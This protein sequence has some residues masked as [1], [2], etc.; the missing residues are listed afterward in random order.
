MDEKEFDLLACPLEK[1]NLIEAGAGTGKTYAI[2]GL[3]LRLLLEKRLSI[4]EILVVTYTVAATE[5]LRDRIRKSIRAAYNA[6]A[7]G[8]SGDDFIHRLVMNHPGRERAMAILKT[9]LAHFDEAPILTI[10]GFC[11]RVLQENAFESLAPFDTVLVP[12]ERILK[13]EIVE[14]FWRINFYDAPP[15]FMAYAMY[16]RSSIGSFLKLTAAAFAGRDLKIDSG[17]AFA[18]GDAEIALHDFRAA[19][20]RLR[21]VWQSCRPEVTN[22]LNSSSLSKVRYRN[23]ESMIAQMD[24]YLESGSPF[25]VFS[26]FEK[27][28]P[29]ALRAA[30][31]KNGKTPEHEFFNRCGEFSDKYDALTRHFEA[32][33]MTLKRGIFSYLR[34][35]L[36]A[37]KEELN[38]QFYDDLLIR[39]RE[40]L[41]QDAS[42]ELVHRLRATYRAALVDEFQDTDPVQFAIFQSVFD[43]GK[44]PLFLIGDPKQSIYSFRG[45]DLFAYMRAAKQ[46]SC[47]YHMKQ[48]F[49]SEPKLVQAVNV[50][51]QNAGKAPF[52][53]DE[54][55]FRPATAA[56]IGDRPCLTID[57]SAEAP[58]NLWYVDAARLEAAGAKSNRQRTAEIIVQAVAM[59]IARLLALGAQGRALI[60]SSPLKEKDMAVLVRT[61]DQARLLHD[62]IAG[63]GIP[64]VLHSL[65]N[66]FDTH[67]AA[68]MRRLLAG[69]W[70]CRSSEA[71]RAAVATDMLGLKGE[72]MEAM[73]GREDGWEYWMQRF[74]LYNERWEKYGFVAMFRSLLGEEKVRQR[75]LKFP[76]G[77]RRVTNVLQLAEVLQGQAVEKRLAMTGLIKW[78]DRQLDPATLRLEE[79][80]LRLESDADAVK[81]VT[82][83]K[84]KGL[85]YPVVFCP[86]NWSASDI[87]DDFFTFHDPEADWQLNMCLGDGGAPQ[88]RWARKELLAENIRLLY[89]SVTRARNRCYLVWGPFK[90]ADSSAPAYIL[91]P[92]QSMEPSGDAVEGTETNFA[93]LSGEDIRSQLQVIAARSEGAISIHDGPPQDAPSLY[94]PRAAG[95]AR[96]SCR[97]AGGLQNADRRV[98]SFSYIVRDRSAATSLA[99][100]E[101][102]ELSESPDRDAGAVTELP[103]PRKP[104]GFFAFPGGARAGS[105]LHDILEQVDFRN[106]DN[107]NLVADKLAVYGFDE[108]WTDEISGMIECLR[109]VELHSAIQGLKLSAVAKEERVSELQF[110]FPLKRLTGDRLKSIFEASGLSQ[111]EAFP[112]WSDRLS[113][114][115]VS[116]CMKGFLDLVFRYGGRYY[117]VDWKSNDLGPAASDY[118]GDNLRSAMAQGFYVLQ[119]HL[120]LVALNEYLRM[121]DASYDYEKD[122]GGVFYIFLRGVDPACGQSGIYYDR[123]QIDTIG[124]LAEHLLD[125]DYVGREP[126]LVEG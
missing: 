109:E 12:D 14:D 29:G 77:E 44:T 65:G 19:F 124:Y 84:S 41:D 126:A 60:G 10:H 66:L 21:L 86:F 22:E 116:G 43:G 6:F 103:P 102:A 36:A 108:A 104:E 11:L 48:N 20:D 8:G 63:K 2:T 105:L 45:A 93:S 49:R 54:I 64:C 79:H 118:G 72:D 114:D 122:F 112:A 56:P 4:R 78:L 98:A 67:E 94:V 120:Y 9:A 47:S 88:R 81:I 70:Q 26:R 24:R 119:Y 85:E 25:P 80:E 46:V 51:F 30:T 125:R 100:D 37:R 111:H 35:E 71:V 27:F 3:F 5:E 55:S 101:S 87:R 99:A 75:L 52:L 58:F 61:N 92:P 39:V 69:I 73:D 117:L 113:F 28:T 107:R 68:E 89:V 7:A 31:N 40:A 32:R 50:L 62:A 16:R 83:H 17:E 15:E 90:E 18:G 121:R 33:L 57:G 34:R 13:R 95:A 59:E 91:H 96:L 1:T 97:S 76:D 42:R 23:I 106:A 74:R 110:Y 82:I 53:Y 115:P 123:P 38:I